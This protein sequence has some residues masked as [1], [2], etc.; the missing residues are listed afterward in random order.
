MKKII[1]LLLFVFSTSASAAVVT[2]NF[3]GV[4]NNTP[5]GNF[6]NGGAG[7]NYGVAFGSTAIGIIDSDA[8]GT[9]PIANEPSPNTV[10]VF[11]TFGGVNN[12][13]INVAAGFDTGFSFF[14]SAS[15]AKS[16][17]I[18]DGLNGTGSLLGT[19]A[20]AAQYNA[21]GC[22]GD[23]NGIFCN[24]SQAGLSFSGVAKS[25]S[26]TDAINYVAF[27]NVTLGANLFA[28]PVPEPETYAMLLSGLGLIG[29]TARRRKANQT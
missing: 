18:Y 26:F 15:Q 5:I 29:F 1:L 4:A 21:N 7:S 19:L 17:S 10:L 28:T 12:S 6:Y 9:A 23:P 2:M 24:W 22:I 20:L 8:G 16:I 14:Y 13:F 25:I 27:D 11:T 3:E